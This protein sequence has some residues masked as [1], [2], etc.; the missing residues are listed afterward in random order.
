M[1]ADFG[2][3][4]D[5]RPGQHGA[6]EHAPVVGSAG[7][8]AHEDTILQD[9]AP[10]NVSTRLQAHT[11]T[12]DRL[13]VNDGLASHQDMITQ[14]ATF[15]DQGV[16]AGF[17]TVP[18]RDTGIDDGSGTDYG[19]LA[20]Y[21]LLGPVAGRKADQAVRLDLTSVADDGTWEDN[22]ESTD[23][24]VFTEEHIGVNDRPG[25]D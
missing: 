2:A 13:P 9:G 8:R 11:R 10:G 16:V 6:G 21:S 3:G 4:L 1:G 24:Y 17:E 12:Q 22:T 19:T 15:P 14:P 18:R 25:P 20:D 23:A 7:I 5:Y